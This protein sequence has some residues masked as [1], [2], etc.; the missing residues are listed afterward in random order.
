LFDDLTDVVQVTVAG[1]APASFPPK[2]EHW[3]RQND[4]HDDDDQSDNGFDQRESATRQR[5]TLQ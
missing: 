1:D 5:R 4:D 2:T 3:Y